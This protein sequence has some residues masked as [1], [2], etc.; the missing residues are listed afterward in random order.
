MHFR[1]NVVFLVVH[2]AVRKEDGQDLLKG[3]K[4]EISVQSVQL[5]SP[6]HHLCALPVAPCS[7]C[8]FGMISESK[9]CS[10]SHASLPPQPD[11]NGNH[12]R[13]TGHGEDHWERQSYANN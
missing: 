2:L 13:N 3:W 4:R 10:N 9:Y 5:T 8:R 7:L 6:K 1:V 11:L 12:M